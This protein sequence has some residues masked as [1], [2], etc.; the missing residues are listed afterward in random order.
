[1]T[2]LASRHPSRW[3]PR[4][5]I[6]CSAAFIQSIRDRGFEVNIQD[7]NHDGHL[8]RGREEFLRRAQRINA[9]GR[10]YGANGFRAA[11]PYRISIGTMR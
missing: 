10:E 4:N 9:Y 8:F 3:C 5:D 1:M 6:R 11:V 7:L 2:L